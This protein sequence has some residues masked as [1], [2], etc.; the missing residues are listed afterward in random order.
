V[1]AAAK[2]FTAVPA[3]VVGAESAAAANGTVPCHHSST[4]PSLL[5]LLI[6]YVSSHMVCSSGAAVTGLQGLPAHI[7]TSIVS[8][9]LQHQLLRPKTLYA[10]VSW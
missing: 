9:L 2:R 5:E 3:A 7:A 10:F 6:R 1:E 4:V 8:D